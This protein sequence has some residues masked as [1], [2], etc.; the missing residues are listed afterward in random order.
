[1]NP[2]FAITWY[3]EKGMRV[4]ILPQPSFP[5]RR[6]SISDAGTSGW[7]DAR[8]QGQKSGQAPGGKWRVR[9]HSRA[10]GNP[11]PQTT[12]FSHA[13]GMGPR[14]RACALTY[15]WNCLITSFPRR[16]EK[17]AFQLWRD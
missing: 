3:F 11:R 8:E 9:R 17:V 2:D 15:D 5:R 10:S 1:M 14:F 4:A 16:F 6:E 13:F 12:P 7:M